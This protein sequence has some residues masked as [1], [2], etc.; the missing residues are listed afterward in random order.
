MI[1]N[2]FTLNNRLFNVLIILLLKILATKLTLYACQIFTYAVLIFFSKV[3]NGLAHLERWTR[4]LFFLHWS[5]C[6]PLE[7]CHRWRSKVPPTAFQDK[8]LILVTYLW[9]LPTVQRGSGS[10]ALCAFQLLTL[11]FEV[12]PWPLTL[13]FNS[14]HAEVTQF[15]S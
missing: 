8:T 6:W 12:W 3:L 13:T 4:P 7:D 1:I 11:N 9:I 2:F 5:Q 14:T 10:V 15:K